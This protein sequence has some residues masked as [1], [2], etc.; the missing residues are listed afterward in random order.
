MSTLRILFFL[1]SGLQLAA[2]QQLPLTVKE[3][4]FDWGQVFSD[5][6][7]EHTFTIRNDGNVS[8]AIARVDLTPPLTI[9]SMPAILPPREQRTIVVHLDTSKSLG[10]FD[11]SAIV[12]FANPEISGV[13]LTLA[14]KVVGRIEVAPWPAFFVAGQKGKITEQSLDIINHESVPV[15]IRAVEHPTDNFTTKLETVDPGWHYRLTLI[16]NAN[17]VTGRHSDRIIL[18]TSSAQNPTVLVEANTILR[19]RVHTFP[20]A[21]DIGTLRLSDIASNPSLLRQGQILMVYQ[22]GGTDFRVSARS[23][24]D[25]ISMSVGRSPAGDRYQILVSLLPDKLNVGAIGGE[26]IIRTSDPEFPELSVPV[27]GIILP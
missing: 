2:S 26:I 19:A 3:T 17:G 11:G 22:D 20:D 7:A 10:R 15:L 5:E 21:L 12:H 4:R 27:K 6:P 8:V 14:A 18:R 1:V 16:L 13:E 9:K 25:C 23:S 24:L